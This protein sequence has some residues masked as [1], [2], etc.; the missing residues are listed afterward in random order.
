MTVNE[1]RQVLAERL[2]GDPAVPELLDTLQYLLD[3]AYDKGYSAG[4]EEGED[5]ASDVW[6][7]S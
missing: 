7:A 3:A 6:G 5:Y 1:F 4:R 2:D